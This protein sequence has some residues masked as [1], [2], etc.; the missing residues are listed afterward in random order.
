MTARLYALAWRVLPYASFT[1]LGATLGATLGV[2]LLQLS[3][4]AK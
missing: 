3:G 1:P 2:L 4:S